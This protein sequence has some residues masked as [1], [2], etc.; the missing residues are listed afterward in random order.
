MIR[1][2][3]DSERWRYRKLKAAPK[4]G[5]TL[6]LYDRARID[7]WIRDRLVVDWRDSCWR[8]RKPIVV[9][10]QFV[11]ARGDEATAR[12]HQNCHGEWLAEQEIRARRALGHAP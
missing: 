7:K 2:I 9:G 4:P 3:P 5:L 8:C 6:T 1:R 11:D 10:Q 12:F